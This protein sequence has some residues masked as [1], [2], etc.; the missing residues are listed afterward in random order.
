MFVPCI[1][2]VP[3]TTIINKTIV[4][5]DTV[6]SLKDVGSNIKIASISGISENELEKCLKIILIT[7]CIFVGIVLLDTIQ[8][9]VFN[10]NVI[11]GIE[12]RCMKKEGL[13]VNTYHCGNGKNITKFKSFNVTSS[14]G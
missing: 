11:I 1:P 2:T 10:N 13:L 12:T 4:Y 14:S 3:R 8:A 5:C 6:L 9:L 7:I